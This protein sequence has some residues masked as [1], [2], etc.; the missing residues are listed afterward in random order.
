MSVESLISFHAISL[1]Y[2]VP[3]TE[4]ELVDREFVQ[5]RGALQNAL[6]PFVYIINN[7]NY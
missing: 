7:A 3:E 1:L 2:G 5:M 6:L 4:F